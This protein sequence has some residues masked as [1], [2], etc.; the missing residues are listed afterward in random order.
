MLGFLE[1]GKTSLIKDLLQTDLY[2]KRLK[3]LIL[4]CEEG[5]EEYE[6]AFLA[7]IGA[8]V[9]YIE[10][11]DDFN[12]DYILPFLKKYKPDRIFI[13]YNGM[14]RAT[15]IIEVYKQ[16][17]DIL[18]DRQVMIQTIDIMND[19]TF[20]MYMKNMPSLMTEHFKVSE[21]IIDNRCTVERTNKNAVRGSIKAVNPRA[22]IVFES[23]DEEFY[24]MKEVMPFDKEAPVI[25][26]SNDDF[27][28]WYIDMMENLDD[29][30]GHT[31]KIRG[32]C[33]KP[34]SLEP[35]FAVLGRR[36]MTCC[37]D[38]IQFMGFLV[39]YDDWSS[40]NN[41]DFIAITAKMDHVFRKEYGE[42]GPVFYAE[43]V[44]KEQAPADDIVYFN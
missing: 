37:A 20:S 11:E 27:G 3:T 1:S 14:W 40:F 10:D 8:V 31:I 15:K 39:K 4:A 25:D 30:K 18:F 21:T 9:E 26:I 23:E 36:V 6:P 44:E 41:K 35:G 29:Y 34:D 7:K 24:K 33:N 13:E 43:K 28:L 16:L 22:Q 42:E 32:F 12:G 2:E 38:D 19:E 5:E 17:C